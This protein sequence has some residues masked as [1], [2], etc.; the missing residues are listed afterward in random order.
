MSVRISGPAGPAATSCNVGRSCCQATVVPMCA[1]YSDGSVEDVEAWV[2]VW[3]CATAC[4]DMVAITNTMAGT[5][6]MARCPM[7]AGREVHTAA[8][9]CSGASP[10]SSGRGDGRS[11]AGD[12][13]SSEAMP[14]D[15]PRHRSITWLMIITPTDSMANAWASRA[16]T[17]NEECSKVHHH[18][19]PSRRTRTTAHMPKKGTSPRGV[20]V[21]IMIPIKINRPPLRTSH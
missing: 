7:G 17:L 10:A 11:R 14:S 2:C 6:G 1:G 16:P 20:N 19:N 18:K 9:D 13:G 4:R 5:R 15:S 3:G 21:A 12:V 8:A